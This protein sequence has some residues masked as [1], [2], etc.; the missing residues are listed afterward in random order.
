M[1]VDKE[2]DVHSFDSEERV[3][4]TGYLGPGLDSGALHEDR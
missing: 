4:R 1:A 3:R 2:I